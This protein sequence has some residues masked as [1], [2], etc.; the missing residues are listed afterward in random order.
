LRSS[1]G[2]GVDLGVVELY[3]KPLIEAVGHAVLL[4]DSDDEL[5]LASVG[6]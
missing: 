5:E 2:S 4:E 6:P 3:A 1:A